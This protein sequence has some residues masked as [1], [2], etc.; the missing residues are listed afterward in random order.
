MLLAS[1]EKAINIVF[2]IDINIMLL[3]EKSLAFLVKNC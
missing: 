2:K 1:L 3:N